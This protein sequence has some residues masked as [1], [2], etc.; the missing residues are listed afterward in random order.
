VLEV[1]AGIFDP[2]EAQR[3]AGSVVVEELATAAR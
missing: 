1:G 2:R 3:L